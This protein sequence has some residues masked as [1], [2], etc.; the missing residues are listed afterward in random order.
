VLRH[1]RGSDDVNEQE[2]GI[3]HHTVRCPRVPVFAISLARARSP[4]P[5]F[6]GVIAR[7]YADSEADE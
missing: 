6:G 7:S 3:P 5:E 2:V 1:V 4:A